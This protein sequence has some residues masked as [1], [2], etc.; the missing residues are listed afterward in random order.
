MRP[1][2]N[3]R[4]GA[5]GRGRSSLHRIPIQKG[6][7]TDLTCSSHLRKDK[8]DSVQLVSCFVN[9]RGKATVGRIFLIAS[10]T[11]NIQS[12]GSQDPVRFPSSEPARHIDTRGHT[13]PHKLWHAALFTIACVILWAICLPPP[14]LRLHVANVVSRAD[15]WF[16]SQLDSFALL[17]ERSTL[18]KHA[19]VSKPSLPSLNSDLVSVEAEFMEGLV[20]N[21]VRRILNELHQD[22]GPAMRD[23]A[24]Q[25]DGAMID[26][27]LTSSCYHWP[28]SLFFP[29]PY[30]AITDDLTIGH[31]WYIPSSSAQL[32]VVLPTPL[33]PSHV[34]IDHIPKYLAANIA[35]APRHMILWG[36]VDGIAN[37]ARWK[38]LG[39]HPS[40]SLHL[41][42]QGPPRS[43]GYTFAPLAKIEYDV[44]D[45]TNVQT[46]SIS[47]PIRN[48]DMDFAIV[49]LE[50]TDNWGSDITCLYRIRVHGDPIHRN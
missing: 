10:D 4:K 38:R 9:L 18:F 11:N 39:A 34:T 13:P 48:A 24:L 17:L 37:T 6:H 16:V 35:V 2:Y 14:M 23:F 49:I 15:T 45:R 47:Q 29:S 30:A 20:E 27:D 33:R 1:R 12:A 19:E 42:R 28:L 26:C 43:L 36:L 31:C 5:S 22:A 46:F 40:D 50:I 32:A 21:I 8:G 3:A 41:N 25:A 44:H 7:Y